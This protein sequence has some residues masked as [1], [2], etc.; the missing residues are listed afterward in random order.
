MLMLLDA[1]LS[2]EIPEKSRSSYEP[3]GRDDD[4]ASNCSPDSLPSVSH[5]VMESGSSPPTGTSPIRSAPVGSGMFCHRAV[6]VRPATAAAGL[7][8]SETPED[9]T[10]N[11]L[12][13]A[14]RCGVAPANM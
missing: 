10:T 2:P 13:T 4:S 11:A 14:T 5:E 3:A 9:M 6:S 7:D 8:V 1:R 12:L